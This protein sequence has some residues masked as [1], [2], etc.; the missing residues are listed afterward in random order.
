MSNLWANVI[1]MALK[2]E[3]EKC[4]GF[5]E[6]GAPTR[7]A[8]AGPEVLRNGAPVRGPGPFPVETTMHHILESLTP[9]SRS[10]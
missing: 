4:Q 10:K 6:S 3:I 7:A 1:T 5:A 2:R 8:Q 9:N